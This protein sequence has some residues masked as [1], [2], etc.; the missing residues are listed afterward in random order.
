MSS[1][2]ITPPPKCLACGYDGICA[3]QLTDHV[4]DFAGA[5]TKCGSF[6]GAHRIAELEAELR[7]SDPPWLDDLLSALGWQGGV[8]AE[9][10]LAV[11]RLVSAAEEQGASPRNKNDIR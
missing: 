2:P 3:G 11:K 1:Q 6:W 10:I 7:R 8:I 5:C 9:A 4:F